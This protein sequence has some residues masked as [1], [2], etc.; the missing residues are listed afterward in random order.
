MATEN[1][2]C[3]AVRQGVD[4]AIADFTKPGGLLERRVAEISD[5][6]LR[7]MARA[8]KRVS[9]ALKPAQ[10]VWQMAFHMMRTDP[11]MAPLVARDRAT[12]ALLAFLADERIKFG[13]RSYVWDQ[14]AA[15]AIARELETDH[16]E[17]V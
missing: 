6:V 15:E 3:R 8:N 17:A 1:G 11:S 4:R 14:A 9:G 5:E 2:M 16:W 7:E 12:A 13:N 10:F